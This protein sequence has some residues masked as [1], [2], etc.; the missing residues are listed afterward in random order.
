MTLPVVVAKAFFR[1]IDRPVIFTNEHR[2]A[3]LDV[4]LL[5]SRELHFHASQTRYF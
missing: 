5:R 2:Q 1:M 4:V 3:A